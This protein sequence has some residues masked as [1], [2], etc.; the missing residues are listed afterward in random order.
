MP[1]IPGETEDPGEGGRATGINSCSGLSFSASHLFTVFLFPSP[2]R[3]G[4][5]QPLAHSVSGEASPIG[6]ASEFERLA[7]RCPT[8]TELAVAQRV[9]DKRSVWV[10]G[11]RPE[12]LP[13]MAVALSSGLNLKV[14]F[15]SPSPALTLQ[16]QTRLGM[17]GPCLLLS[18]RPQRN[19]EGADS[20]QSF[21]Y[22]CAPHQLDPQ[23]IRRLIGAEG[24]LLIVV[25]DAHVATGASSSFR[26]SYQRLSK[27]LETW[28]E[29][30]VLASS[31]PLDIDTKKSASQALGIKKWTN[32]RHLKTALLSECDFWNKGDLELRVEQDEKAVMAAIIGPLPRPALV[33]CGTPAQADAVYGELTDAQVPVHRFHSGMSVGDRARELLHFALPGRRAIMVA[34]SAFSPED[35]LLADLSPSPT[36]RI[37]ETFGRGYA[38]DDLRSIVHL[39]APYSLSQYAQE[40]SLLAMPTG[41]SRTALLHFDPSHLILNSALLERKRPSPA[42]LVGVLAHLLGRAKGSCFS[43]RELSDALGYSPKQLGTIIAYLQDA[44][45]LE[46]KPD[47]LSV[48]LP[49]EQLKQL[50]EQLL[51]DL[52]RLIAGDP[53]RLQQVEDYAIAQGC[54]IQ[55][56]LG[57]FDRS[58][59]AKACGRCDTCAP[60]KEQQSLELG[61]IAAKALSIEPNIETRSLSRRPHVRAG[62]GS[63]DIPDQADDQVSKRG[64]VEDE[65]LLGQA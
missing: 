57:P 13:N 11:L 51:K 42:L 6:F 36:S 45:A 63:A 20:K 58:S 53:Q 28:P 37:P 50:V 52:E 16:R 15:V 23:T 18:E 17:R 12:S 5:Q 60:E 35:S 10:E 21:T 4:N 14:L 34:V 65:A 27:V 8:E 62:K 46:S 7:Q 43:E 30:Q 41:E 38:R 49:A 48:A 25:E 59:L 31:P 40:L 39:C 44:G 33:L 61:S 26:P 54:R 55:S 24:P 32:L 3:D 56:L 64:E 1:S 9:S 29:A 19:R 47:G 2:K 22:W